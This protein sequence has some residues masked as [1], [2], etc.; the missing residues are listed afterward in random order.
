MSLGLVVLEKKL[1]TWTRMRTRTPTP[2][3][4]DIM[5]ADIKNSMSLGLVVLDEKLFTRTQTRTPTPQ[6]N[7]IMS[8]S[9]LT[10][11]TTFLV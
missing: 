1:F 4:D 3:S 7:Y 8:A 2:Q 9:Q 5:S 6:S 11:K 10:Y